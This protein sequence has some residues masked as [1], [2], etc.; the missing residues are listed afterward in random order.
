MPYPLAIRLPIWISECRTVICHEDEVLSTNESENVFI[1]VVSGKISAQYQQTETLIV[2]GTV[3]ALGRKTVVVLHMLSDTPC[4]Y[5]LLRYTRTDTAPNVDLNNLCLNIASL[6]TFFGLKTRFCAIPDTA[7]AHLILNEILYEWQHDNL[8]RDVVLRELL[9]L[10]LLK[11]SRAFRAVREPQGIRYLD[12]ARSYIL[13]HYQDELSVEDIAAY[14]GI[15]R[16]YLSELFVQYNDRCIVDYIQAVRCSRAAFLLATTR[17]P[18]VDI[19]VE[20]GFNSRQN[21]ARTFRKQ[22]GMSPN[23]YRI[24]QR[25]EK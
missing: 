12:R 11:V 15:S 23:E 10:F 21:F 14:A 25:R 4:Q 3:I 6:D 5:T 8:D 20:S 13:E 17:F 2:P 1:Q 9:V 22:Y 24:S 18:I 19:A 16:S 7:Y